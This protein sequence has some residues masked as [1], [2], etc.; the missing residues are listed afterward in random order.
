M[1]LVETSVSLAVPEGWRVEPLAL[2]RMRETL[3][4][5]GPDIVG[6]AALAAPLLPGS[7]HRVLAEWSVLDDG[8]PTAAPPGALAGAVLLRA[9]TRHEIVDGGVVVTGGSVVVDPRARVH[10]PYVDPG[11]VAAAAPEGRSPFPNRPVVVLLSSDADAERAAWAGRLADA[12]LDV[13]VE[14]RVAT[15]ATTST[16]RLTRACLPTAESLATLRPDV[17]VALD[18]TAVEQAHTWCAG[19]RATVV[20]RLDDDVA[21]IELVPWRLGVSQGRLRALVGPDVDAPALARLVN[22]LASGPLPGLPVD[23]DQPIPLGSVRRRRLRS[24]APSVAVVRAALD[25]TSQR[26]AHDVAELWQDTQE[27]VVMADADAPPAAVADAELLVVVGATW[28]PPLLEMV[29]SRRAAGL[30]TIVDVRRSDL[31]DVDDEWDDRPRDVRPEAEAALAS[32]SRATFASTAL[33]QRTMLGP[34]PRLVLPTPLPLA[35]AEAA[36][37]HRRAARDGELVVGWHLGGAPDGSAGTA[38]DQA[39]AEGLFD[40]LDAAP[41]VRVELFGDV[42]RAP[43]ALTY[44]ER[45]SAVAGQRVGVQIAELS[46]LVWTPCASDVIDGVHHEVLLAIASGV[47]VQWATPAAVS[48]GWLP[49]PALDPTMACEA[50]SWAELLARLL[51]D[52]SERAALTAAARELAA[53]LVDPVALRQHGAALRERMS[54]SR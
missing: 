47:P 6:V 11:P 8:E 1:T 19:I 54:G 12:L 35:I 16:S 38:L 7:S 49:S 44:D 53:G 3:D 24:V 20:V 17:V 14:A 25:D 45:V 42:G 10:D 5:S 15:A 33:Q 52:E 41:G 18:G 22:R 21:G 37:E 50:E 46:L 39:V 34:V 51:D 26:R 4:A 13:D 36:A 9:G 43:A 29:A 2:A 30:R 27:A 40:V 31:E 48:V 23:V 32:A 28:P